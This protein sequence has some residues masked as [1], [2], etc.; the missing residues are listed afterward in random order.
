VT[1]PYTWSS[2]QASIAAALVQAQSPYTTVPADFAQL[3]PN[4]VSYAEGRIARD[5]V[6]LNTRET[7]TSLSTTAGSRALPSLSTMAVPIIVPEYL[8]LIVSGAYLPFTHTSLDLIN[9]TWPQQALQIAPA[10]VDQS[11]RMWTLTSDQVI[12]I[13]PTP[14][15]ALVAAITGLFIQTPMSSSNPTTY[16]GNVYGDLLFCACMI[17]LSGA[18]LRNFSATGDEPSLAISWENQYG[19]LLPGAKA[20][21]ARRRGLIPDVERPPAAPG[22]QQAA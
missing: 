2:L 5:L 7:D 19:R 16:I 21:E 6:L 15:A 8:A 14:N 18:L 12:V 3:F 17:F 13:A 1:T 10:T 22:G 11:A 4:A 9:W 20:E